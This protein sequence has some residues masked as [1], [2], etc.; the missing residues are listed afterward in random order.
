MCGRRL[1]RGRPE[2]D[3]AEA[4]RKLAGLMQRPAFRTIPAAAKGRV[5]AIWH[6]F[7]NSP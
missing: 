7:Y 2:P 3:A 6:Q 5:H 1:G 4:R